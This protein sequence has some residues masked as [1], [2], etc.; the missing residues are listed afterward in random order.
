MVNEREGLRVLPPD[1]LKALTKHVFRMAPWRP[2]GQWKRGPGGDVWTPR[3]SGV[4]LLEMTPQGGRS[5]LF[6]PF[7]VLIKILLHSRDMILRQIQIQ[8]TLP[9]CTA[10]PNDSGK[11]LPTVLGRGRSPP[12][13]PAASP[14]LPRAEPGLSWASG[15]GPHCHGRV[16]V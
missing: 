16:D 6:F 4:W 3:H 13:R 2:H 15:P 5:H 12:A 1:G 14:G 8:T 11:L 7:A 9:I 10:D